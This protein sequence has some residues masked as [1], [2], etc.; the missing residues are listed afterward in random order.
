[1][2]W[3]P[4]L[5]KVLVKKDVYGSREQYTRPTDSA[6]PMMCGRSKSSGS[7][8]RCMGPTGKSVSH[9]NAFLVKKKK[10][11][12]RET[13]NAPNLILIQTPS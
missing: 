1:M 9:V 5:I 3:D 11:R 4:F 6:I 13:R 7:Y 10:K 8:A 2:S 12:K